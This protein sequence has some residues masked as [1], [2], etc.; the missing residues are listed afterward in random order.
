[1]APGSPE[2]GPAPLEDKVGV[3]CHQET[4]WLV[5]RVGAQAAW[6]WLGPVYT[7]ASGLPRVHIQ[8]QQMG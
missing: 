6:V 5:L 4:G 1:M 7:Q 2:Y 8:P 3:G